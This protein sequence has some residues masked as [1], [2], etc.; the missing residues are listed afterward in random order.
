MRGVELGGIR[1]PENAL[2]A[3]VQPLRAAVGEHAPAAC[4]KQGVA[5]EQV[6]VVEQIA[7]VAGGVPCGVPH[8]GAVV[9]PCDAVALAHN[10]G[11]LR[12]VFRAVNKAA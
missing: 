4:G 8:G 6:L 5:G 10:V 1:Q 7:A 3:V 2:Q 9:L 11:G 12:D